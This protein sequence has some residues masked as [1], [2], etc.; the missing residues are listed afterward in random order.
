MKPRDMVLVCVCTLPYVTR[1]LQKLLSCVCDGNSLGQ[2]TFT[3]SQLPSFSCGE[4]YRRDHRRRKALGGSPDNVLQS[5]PTRNMGKVKSWHPGHCR[6]RR[7]FAPPCRSVSPSG[8]GTFGFPWA[9]FVCLFS[10]YCPILFGE[11]CLFVCLL[12]L[13]VF[14]GDKD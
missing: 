13:F 3:N 2:V 7:M 10:C 14:T 1:G 4:T 11:G 12:F 8:K 6:N 9:V 5:F